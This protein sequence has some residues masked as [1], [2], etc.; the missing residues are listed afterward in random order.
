MASQR[1]AESLGRR[2]PTPPSLTSSHDAVWSFVASCLVI[3]VVARVTA[4][5]E[6]RS[7]AH[8][9]G[10]SYSFFVKNLTV[11]VRTLNFLRLIAINWTGHLFPSGLKPEAFGDYRRCYVVA[12]YE[13]TWCSILRHVWLYACLNIWVKTRGDR[14]GRARGS[15]INSRECTARDS[16]AA[17]WPHTTY[18]RVISTISADVAKCC[19]TSTIAESC[20]YLG[21]SVVRR[22]VK[23]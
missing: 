20:W 7:Q 22:F 1:S 10:K 23:E 5:H 15:R 13:G 19:V 17:I 9:S 8:Q 11:A 3:V 16:L 6:A 12:K 2:D 21:T 18:S 4:E 14:A